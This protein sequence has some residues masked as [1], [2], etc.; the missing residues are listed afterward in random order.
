[1]KKPLLFIPS[2]KLDVLKYIR[3]L[4]AVVRWMKRGSRGTVV[5]ATGF[6]KTIIGM[7]AI[8]KMKKHMP[9]RKA[10]IIVPSVILYNQWTALLKIFDLGDVASI[11]IINTVS[12]QDTVYTV[13]F[14]ILD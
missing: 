8:S 3:Q 6:G 1:M 12:L 13:D 10:L 5:A 9:G 11:L 7:I 2:D 14:L 4:R